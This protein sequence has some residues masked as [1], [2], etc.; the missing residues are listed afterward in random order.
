MKPSL[1]IVTLLCAISLLWCSSV[2]AVT[3]QQA[4]TSG[5]V[6]EQ[7]NGYLG[8]VVDSQE[9]QALVRV[10]NEKRK[11]YYLVI[12][13]R[14]HIKLDTVAKLAAQ[15]AIQAAESGHIIQTP[16]GKWLTK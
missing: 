5:W 13:E 14:N 1:A 12:A 16:Q 4:K 3:L 15:K 8:V 6:G 7:T 11:K 10:V 9:T 2:W